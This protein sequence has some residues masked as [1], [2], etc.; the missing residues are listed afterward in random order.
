MKISLVENI[1]KMKVLF[2]PHFTG[3]HTNAVW[4]LAEELLGRG[5]EVVLLLA[6]TKA[7][8]LE[9]KGFIVELLDVSSC[10]LTDESWSNSTIELISKNVIPGLWD[11]NRQI[12]DTLKKVEPNVI[13]WD[14]LYLPAIF[15]SKVPLVSFWSSNPIGLLL[16]REAVQYPLGEV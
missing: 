4:G 8:Q 7:K 14:T 6:P 13:V 15:M 9:T 16:P 5:N 3:G 1:D 10:P 2:V 12:S 11:I